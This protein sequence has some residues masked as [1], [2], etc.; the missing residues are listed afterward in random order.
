MFHALIKH[1]SLIL[2][3]AVRYRLF[4]P[5]VY[6]KMDEFHLSERQHQC[7][8]LTFHRGS[9]KIPLI[10]VDARQPRAAQ[11]HPYPPQALCGYSST[12]SVTMGTKKLVSQAREKKKNHCSSVQWLLILAWK[13]VMFPKACFWQSCSRAGGQEHWAEPVLQCHK[14]HFWTR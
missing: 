10:P 3:S 13:P 7:P 9:I 4:S 8:A 1:F 5:S 2:H 12:S 6:P 11:H 14:C